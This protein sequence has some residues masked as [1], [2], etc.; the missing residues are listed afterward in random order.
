MFD[1]EG[2]KREFKGK[3]RVEA[4]TDWVLDYLRTRSQDR[5]FFLMAS[6]LEPHQQNDAN[7]FVGPDGSQDAFKTY[8]KPGDLL[9]GKGNWQQELPDY[10]GACHSLDANM[11]CVRAEL[12]KL[13]LADNTLVIYTADHSCHFKMRNNEYKRACQDNAT[14]I[15]LIVCGPGFQGGKV[16][17][18][19]ASLLDVPSTILAA[20]GVPPP[21][22]CQGQP[23]QK[24]LSDAPS[25][26]RSEVFIQISES[27]VGRAL[28]HAAVDVCGEGA[29]QERR[30][31]FQQHGVHRGLP[32]R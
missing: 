21:A 25:A 9:P 5:P 26:W 8:R 2:N 22:S 27:Q 31:Y 28:R 17:K 4:Q 23:L 24:T 6:Y 12:E 32:L 20:A 19:L 16:V 11:G 30:G 14:H 29:R 1:A 7:R 13:G 10:L 15:P 3:Y 18:E